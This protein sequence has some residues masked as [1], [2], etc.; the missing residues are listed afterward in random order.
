LPPFDASDLGAD[1]R[2]AVPEI[3]GAIFRP[4]HD[5]LVMDKKRLHELVSLAS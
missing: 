1:Q 3:L 4:Y 2:R 5:M